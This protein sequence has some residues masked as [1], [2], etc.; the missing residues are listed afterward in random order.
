MTSYDASANGALRALPLASFRP[1]TT[2]WAVRGLVP[3]G[4]LTLVAGEGGLGKSSLGLAW[5]RRLTDQGLAA[6]VI[7][8]EDDAE[9]VLWQ[10][11]TALGG[12]HDLLYVVQV[13]DSQAEVVFPH[14]LSDLDDRIR[15]T[16]ARGVMID[17]VSASLDLALD[18][19]RD[20]DV[21]VVLARLHQIATRRDVALML[22]GHLNKAESGDAY[23]RING[24]TAFYN[25]A[26]SVVTVSRDPA[27]PDDV[28]LV[29]HQKSNYSRVA[30]VERWRMLSTA[31]YDRDGASYPSS[32]I[33]FVETA[34]DVRR[35]D[36][37]ARRRDVPRDQ[38][39]ELLVTVLADGERS[40]REIQ[41]RAD[42]LGVSSATLQ[43]A[44]Q[45]LGVLHRRTGS[46]A[47]HT[48]WWRLAGALPG[49]GPHAGPPVALDDQH[50]GDRLGRPLL[51]CATC[52]APTP[53]RVNLGVAFCDGCGITHQPAPPGLATLGDEG[54]A[55]P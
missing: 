13:G 16:G 45:D 4:A 50:G 22:F 33:E 35:E 41:Q 46:G 53:H 32:L 28:R 24:S 54:A 17:P 29:A 37:L 48:T 20:Q 47:D 11:F 18:S 26:R 27:S 14:H 3:F 5:L 10:R 43:R 19:H 36:V 21:R 34:E 51:H 40:S 23:M 44:R 42:A 9:R 39:R 52:G 15:E 30:P 12:D 31:V 25:A 1:R 2:S 49:V 8:Y 6:L 55:A 38:A 7:S